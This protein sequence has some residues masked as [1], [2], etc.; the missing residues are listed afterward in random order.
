MACRYESGEPDLQHRSSSNTSIRYE[1]RWGS[2]DSGREPGLRGKSKVRQ[3]IRHRYES[4]KPC[5]QHRDR[6]HTAHGIGSCSDRDYSGRNRR[7]NSESKFQQRIRYRYESRQSYVQYGDS[8]DPLSGTGAIGMAISSDGLRA[9]VS[10][11][12]SN[13]VS[14]IDIN[15]ISPTFNTEIDLVPVSG[16]T[17]A[18]NVFVRQIQPTP[19]PTPSGT[20]FPGFSF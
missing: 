15:P 7:L 19:P 5:L 10:N 6:P 9:Y 18:G 8:S 1:P 12:T 3:R 2:I 11:T 13:N 17:P 16:I 14:V 4:C 20:L